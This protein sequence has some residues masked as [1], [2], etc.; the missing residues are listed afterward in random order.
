MEALKKCDVEL[1]HVSGPEIWHDVLDDNNSNATEIA[2]RATWDDERRQ[3][4]QTERLR[5]M[6]WDRKRHVNLTEEIYQRDK[7]M[8]YA[9]LNDYR[10]HMHWQAWSGYGTEGP[11]SEDV[12][13]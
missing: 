5:R 13:Q 11:G 8:S 12:L 4:L 7:F 3:L 10:E 6:E 1:E 9:L 2:R